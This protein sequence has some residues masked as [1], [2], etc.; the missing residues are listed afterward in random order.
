MGTKSVH[1][2][3]P[4]DKVD[5]IDRLVASGRY[6]NTT[7]FIVEAVNELVS[8]FSGEPTVRNIDNKIQIVQHRL[9]AIEPKVTKLVELH[10]DDF[11]GGS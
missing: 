2:R 9:N 5:Y 8:R 7:E 10:R 6:K 4:K 3:L 1:I 11:R